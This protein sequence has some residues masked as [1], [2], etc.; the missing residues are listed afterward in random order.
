MSPAHSDVAISAIIPVGGRHGRAADLYAEYK[1]GLDA[2]GRPYEMIFVL[3]G[4]QPDFAAGLQQLL[5]SGERFTVVGLTRYF[6]EATSIMAGFGRARGDLIVTLPGYHQIEGTE[7]GKLVAALDGQDLV[8]GRRWPRA[9]GALEKLRRAAFH[10]LLAWVTH[11]QFNDLACGARAFKRRVLEE[12]SLYGDQHRFLPVIADRQGFRVREVDVRQSTKDRFEGLYGPREYLRSL[13]DIFSIFFVVRFTKRP[14]RFFGMVGASAIAL[15]AVWTIVLVVQRLFFDQALA[16]RPA[17]LL[18]T[19]L[20]VLGLQL[21]AIGL[22]G[23]LIIFTHAR[24]LRDYQVAE[25]I[26]FPATAQQEHQS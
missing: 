22:L 23:E 12:I 21:F 14:L 24:Q 9:G 13:L 17:L 7:I 10:G 3:D 5:A 8:V 4:P 1:A 15:G 6:G 11:L 18:A 25:V 26:Q 20:L 16:D 19:L 2:I